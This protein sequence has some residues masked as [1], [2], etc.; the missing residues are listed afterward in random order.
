VVDKVREK[1]VREDVM[2]QLDQREND[3]L[4]QITVDMM[5]VRFLFHRHAF[6]YL[7]YL[8]FVAFFNLTNWSVCAS[9]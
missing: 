9:S 4:P 7:F 2:K 8:I 1:K 5:E 6:V 3:F